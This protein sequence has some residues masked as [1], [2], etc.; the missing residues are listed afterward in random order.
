MNKYSL[1][2][3]INIKDNRDIHIASVVAPHS[4]PS[5]N[6]TDISML[7]VED[8]KDKGTCVGQ[9]EGKGQE[10]R[11]Y[12]ETGK[13]TRLSKRYIYVSSKLIDGYDGQGTQPRVAAKILTEKG[14]PDQSLVP[15]NNDLPYAEYLNI[16]VS[17]A[18]ILTNASGRRVKG[19]VFALTLDDV[20]TLIDTIKVFNLTLQV[21]DWSSIPV[22][23]EP[24]EGYHRQIA[25]GY[26]DALNNN[27]ADTKIYILNSWG[28][29]W[30]NTYYDIKGSYF[31]WWS[32]YEHYLFDMMGY[33]DMPDTVIDYTKKIPYQFTRALIP[34]MR[35]PDIMELQKRLS[36]ETAADGLP[37]YRYTEKDVLFFS[38]LFGINTQQAVE[39]Y[40]VV[41][42]I[43]SFGT[44]KTTG[45]GQVGPKTLRSLNGGSPS[46]ETK[47]DIWADAAQEFEG[48]APGSRSYRN[49]NPGNIKYSGVFKTMAIGEDRGAIP[50]GSPG[51]CIFK[52]Y[53]SGR[54][55]LETLFK[56][57]CSG[58]SDLYKPQMSLIDF[59]RTYAPA[60]DN[61][62]PDRYAG[63]VAAKIGIST[64]TQIKNLII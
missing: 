58:K 41:H 48:W 32:E 53:T 62:L 37:C 6:I 46:A 25:F 35:G 54:A 42:G 50:V 49:N 26:E 3:Q 51:F 5:K 19:Y 11:E 18:E 60:S 52:D 12:L 2:A 13:F 21:G 7:P 61:N 31:I 30:G 22:H 47:I 4:H 56:N 39:R 16:D 1:G 45:Y 40:Q 36:T 63:F 44:P 29:Q 8:Q 59:Y 43:A 64:D 24:N 55:A 33:I 28:D 38:T 14:T 15:D 20:K 57:A 34:G 9:A 17:T 23:P 27:K 10:F